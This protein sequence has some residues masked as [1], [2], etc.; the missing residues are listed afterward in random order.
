MAQPRLQSSYDVAPGVQ[1]FIGGRT[2]KMLIDGKWV[3]AASGKTL[4]TYDPATEEPLAEVPAGDK[5]D[6]DRAVKAA[7]KAFSEGPW[8]KL[9]GA[10]RGRILMK[11]SALIAEL[12][13]PRLG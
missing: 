10:E 9:S 5:E 3:E 7:R 4:T 2:R 12:V 13:V 11:L 8:S 6:I 1:Q